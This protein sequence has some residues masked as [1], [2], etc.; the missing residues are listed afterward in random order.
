MT[1]ITMSVEDCNDNLVAP[2]FDKASYYILSI[3]EPNIIRSIKSPRIGVK[4]SEYF[5]KLGINIAII[6]VTWNGKKGYSRITY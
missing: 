5:A 2:P 6:S 1:I 3:I 4:L